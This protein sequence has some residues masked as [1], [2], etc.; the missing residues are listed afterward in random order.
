LNHFTLPEL[1]ILLLGLLIGRQ[2]IMPLTF[3]TGNTL[4]KLKDMPYILLII[5]YFSLTASKIINIYSKFLNI[6]GQIF[7][8]YEI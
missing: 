2:S 4:E 7:S 8:A 5:R 3:C 6:K 1:T